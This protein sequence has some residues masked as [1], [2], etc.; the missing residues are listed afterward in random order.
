MK[1]KLITKQQA[2]QY[3]GMNVSEMDPGKT[4]HVFLQPNGGMLV[5]ADW[6]EKEIIKLIEAAE[7]I[8]IGGTMCRSMNHGVVV[9]REGR[10]YFVESKI[11]EGE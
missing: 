10:E 7:R 3:I 2:Y 11:P 9:T 6:S 5:G 8:E 1:E 4:I